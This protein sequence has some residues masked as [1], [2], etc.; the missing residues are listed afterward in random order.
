MASTEETHPQIHAKLKRLLKSH[1][2]AVAFTN[3]PLNL[4]NI[5]MPS[6]TLDDVVLDDHLAADV[7]EF[8]EEHQRREELQ[9]FGLEARHKVLISGPEGNGKTILAE[10]LAHSL[11]VVFIAAKYSGLI[12]SNL[13]ETG[14]KID[15]IFQYAA[16]R[17]S[18]L[19]VDEFDTV[20][21]QRGGNSM[22]VGEAR[23]FTNQLLISMNTLPA[24]TVIVAAT[25]N[26]SAIDRAARRRFDFEISLDT[27]TQA[28]RKKLASKELAPDLTP[29][30][31]LMIWA[32]EVADIKLANLDAVVKLCRQIRRDQALYQGRGIKGIILRAKALHHPA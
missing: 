18:L 12:C 13:G 22:D 11:G 1:S 2:P 30:A 17:P 26:L 28:I 9:A 32:D 21:T 8:L 14:K 6:I 31:D 16:G 5:G 3:P 10:A 29:G 15:E 23:R 27:P 7:R 24:H 25:N 20:A 4:A 19:F